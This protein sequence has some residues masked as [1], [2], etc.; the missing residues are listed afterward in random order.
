MK[1][2]NQSI[3]LQGV[4][5]LAITLLLW[6]KALMSPSPIVA[7][8]GGLLFDIVA[9]WLAP[10]PL[11][12]VILAMLLV[13]TEGLTLNLLL[14]SHN[15]TSQN[16]LLPTLLYIVCMSAPATTLS[17][18]ILANALLIACTQ[19]LLLTGSLLTISTDRACTTTAFIGIATL[20]YFPAVILMLSYMLVAIN[21]RLYSWK[22]WAV[23]FLGFLAPYIMVVAVMLFTDGLAGWWQ[24]VVTD[25]ASMKV[26][27]GEF[28]TLQALGNS[29]M[30]LVM[31]AGVVGVWNQSGESTVVWQK[32]ATT[33]LTLIIGGAV[34][35]FVTR[36]FTAD[37][38]FFALPFAFSVACLLTPRQRHSVGRRRKE[39]VYTLVLIIT[40]VAAAI[41]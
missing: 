15:L 12:A 20:F 35:L 2:F 23:L 26:T 27:I 25:L 39:W 37:M 17:P 4:V 13:V 28:T 6:G 41:C 3:L 5:I 19:Q 33:I 14:A 29:V 7:D 21:Y 22:D 32:N 8:G 38:Q 18:M 30:L 31:I 36:L 1:L 9:G 34:M 40:I 16:S 24:S 11:L 10:V